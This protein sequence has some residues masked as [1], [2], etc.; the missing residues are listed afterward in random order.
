[1]KPLRR[2]RAV[3]PKAA[4]WEICILAGGL[5]TR[6]GRDKSRLRLGSR[7]LIGH[8]RHAARA[9]GVPVRVV[10]RDVVPRCG[11]LGGVLT[12]LERTRADAVLFLACDMPWV[13]VALLRLVMRRLRAKDQA[14]FVGTGRGAGF[15]FAVRREA[16]PRVREQ[17][18]AGDHSLQALA[19]RLGG[20][21]VLIP[22]RWR[23]QLRN[24]NTPQ[25]LAQA[26]RLWPAAR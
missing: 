3:A 23:A 25:E 24:L 2:T 20:R 5:S 11:P 6:M 14:V 21:R 22:A 4:R 10:R 13:S 1:M 16:L 18:A 12:A 8:A 19:R 26:R 15:P 9:V 17:L 7:T